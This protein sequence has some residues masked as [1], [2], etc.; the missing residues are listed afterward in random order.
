MMSEQT[1]LNLVTQKVKERIEHIQ[2]LS[3]NLSANNFEKMMQKE[4]ARQIAQYTQ[5]ICEMRRF[6]AHLH[7]SL[8]C[9]TVD[10]TEFRI[11]Y[12][13]Y[14]DAIARQTSEVR[15]FHLE[16]NDAE[17]LLDSRL[18]WMDNFLQFIDLNELDRSSLVKMI[19]SIR[20]TGKNDVSISFV[21]QG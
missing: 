18:I 6:V 7:D 14:D 1:L 15:S 10:D 19:R 8:I 3:F 9:G 5:S 21:G 2:E 12:D 11:L 4:C 17:K 13:Y 16:T 20:I